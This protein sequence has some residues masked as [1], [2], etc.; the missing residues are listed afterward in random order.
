VRVTAK[1]ALPALAKELL[2]LRLIA[3]L[4]TIDA[5]GTPH[6]VPMWFVHAEGSVLIPTSSRTKKVRNLRR[7]PR[8]T[9][10]VEQAGGGLDVRGAMLVGAVELVEG[11]EARRLNHSI[12]LKYVTA[13]GLAL[14]EV[15][16][17][18]D[19]D[20]VTIRLRPG[21]V[22]TWDLTDSPGSR[23]L[24]RAGLALPLDG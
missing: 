20:D 18:L 11:A 17:Y 9:L 24:A 10:M 16:G 14:P 2:G 19:T 22:T 3:T 7:T 12:H 23:A 6:V 1:P 5:D 21:R 4:A 8:A 15:R 13:E